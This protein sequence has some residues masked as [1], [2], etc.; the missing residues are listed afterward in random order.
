[1]MFAGCLLQ[2]GALQCPLEL[3]AGRHHLLRRLPAGLPR[4][5]PQLQADQ[6]GGQGAG[7]VPDQQHGAQLGDQAP[8]PADPQSGEVSTVCSYGLEDEF[9]IKETVE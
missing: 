1:M 8:P 3:H 5:H 7:R 4:H 6:A 9:N 2:S